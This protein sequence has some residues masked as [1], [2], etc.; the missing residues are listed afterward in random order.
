M[1]GAGVD[2]ARETELEGPA[3]LEE[4]KY[5]QLV[6][7]VCIDVGAVLKLFNF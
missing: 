6:W 3:E 2:G 4:R 1:E 5:F 7:V